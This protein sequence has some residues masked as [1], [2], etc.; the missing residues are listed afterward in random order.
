MTYHS[1][2]TI[3]KFFGLC[4][5]LI[6]TYEFRKCLF[7]DN[8]DVAVLREARHEHFFYR[9]H[10]IFQES[11][12]HQLA[13]LHD[14]AV[15]GGNINLTLEYIIQFGG[16]EADFKQELLD[17]KKDMDVLYPFIKVARNKLLSHNDYKTMIGPDEALG[18][19]AEGEDI[20]YF[21]ALKEFCEKLSQ[22]VLNESFVYDDL[23]I[24]D[25]DCFMSQFIAGKI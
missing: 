3:E 8:Q 24:N 1:T 12:M 2:K 9:I 17:L 15:M 22:K 10:V 18:E 5:W 13:K 23:V 21:N 16:W 19:F 20:N 14:P 7:D 4:D 25:V 6:Q 11:W